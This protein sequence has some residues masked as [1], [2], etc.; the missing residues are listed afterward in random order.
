MAPWR[1]AGAVAGSIVLRGARAPCLTGRVSSN[2][3]PQQQP[4]CSKRITTTSGSGQSLAPRKRVTSTTPTRRSTGSELVVFYGRGA[5]T[6][7]VGGVRRVTL[8]DSQALRRGACSSHRG[9][10][11]A[12][13]Y[14]VARH[15][16][17]PRGAKVER[18]SPQVRLQNF[19]C[20][21]RVAA[22]GR[23]GRV[24]SESEDRSFYSV[25]TPRRAGKLRSNPS[26]ERRPREAGRPWA[27]QGSRRLHCPA[28]RQGAMP[29][30]SR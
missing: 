2:V 20:T 25:L 19:Q 17:L 22:R 5:R 3:R 10:P 16:W 30:G 26:L 21:T 23:G 14:P 4:M 1:R 27:T 8:Q 6:S 18:E 13:P 12:R 11:N 15:V 9:P 24:P 28:R 29:H 7:N